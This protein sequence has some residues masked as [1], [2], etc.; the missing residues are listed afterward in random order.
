MKNWSENQEWKP[1]EFLQPST[2]EEIVNIVKKAVQTNQN[3]RVF[4][5]K[6]SFTALNNTEAIC[7]NLDNYQGIINVDK[8]TNYVTVKSGTKLFN[9][10][11]LLADHNLAPENMGDVD[12]QSIAGAIGTGTHGTGIGLGNVSTQVTAIKF[13]NGLGDVIFC[14]ETI[15]TELFKCMQ[16]SLGVLGIVTEVTLK[17]VPNYKLKLEKKAEKLTDVLANLNYLNNTNR[18]FE[19]Y[20]LPY[21]NAVQTKYSNITQGKTDKDS[22]LDYFNDVII[23]NH[24]L[25]FMC[26]TAKVFPKLRV[27]VSKFSSKFLSASTKTKECKDI[28][29]T[30]RL[31]KFSEMEYN[32]PINAYQD[33]MKDV[34]KC[35][36]SKKF[37]IHFPIE[38][39][40]VKG[41]DIYLSPSYQRD[42]AY[43]ACHVYKGK[44]YKPYFK[45]LEEIFTAY[46]GRPHW[47]KLH[48]KK[49]VYFQEK[50]PM[51]DA[52]NR[53][54][55]V[56]DPN[57]I[58]FN[59][60]LRNLLTV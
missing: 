53:N 18:N 29:A 58:F 13:V 37:N 14:S 19:F 51:F 34:I 2:E 16:I 24:V 30:P 54:R 33:V 7:L 26:D 40:F 57:E 47:G 22:F 39:R 25:K 8:T 32:V 28:Y 52:F 15:N 60:H 3:V 48:F 35:V 5:T 55:K 56:H 44:D 10:T 49:G 50:Y 11:K 17:C 12:K 46:E 6:H 31:V 38:N 23:E 9:L 59:P 21:T 1:N 45:A 43:I 42:S 4:G 27:G 20:W 41:D 36:N